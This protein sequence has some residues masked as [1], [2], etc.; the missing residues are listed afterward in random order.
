MDTQK[1]VSAMLFGLVAGILAGLVPLIVGSKKR[2]MSLGLGGFFACAISGAVL[3]LILAVPIAGIF[4]WLIVR[5][6]KA[7]TNV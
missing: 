6:S 4:T 2:Q 7:Q 3:G 1:I 5:N